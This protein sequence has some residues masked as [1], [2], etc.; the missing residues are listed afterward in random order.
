[1]FEREKLGFEFNREEAH[2][3]I[4]IGLTTQQKL[5]L[6]RIFHMINHTCR[7]T[8]SLWYYSNP[9]VCIHVCKTHTLVENGPLAWTL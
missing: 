5:K 3:R 9:W 2:S 6:F 8:G 7:R 4:Y 1:M